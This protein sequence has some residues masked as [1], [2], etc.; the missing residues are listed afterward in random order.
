MKR[1][2]NVSRWASAIYRMGNRF[3]D[4]ALARD[5]I[6]CGQQFF[7]LRIQEEQG[8]GVN[9]LAKLGRFDKGTAARAVQ[10]L[11]ELGYLRREED[12]R[13]KRAQRLYTTEQAEPVMATAREAVEQWNGILTKGLTQEERVAA[14]QLLVKMAENAATYLKQEEH[15]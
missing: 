10:K 2:A 8:I 1:Q 13:D 6:G 4:R 15:P 9:E 3:Y 12:P 5:G 14:E 11:E 7:L